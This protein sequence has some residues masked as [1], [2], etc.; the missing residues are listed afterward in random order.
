MP[1]ICLAYS[2]SCRGQKIQW[3]QRK[4]SLPFV[5]LLERYSDVNE[6]FFGAQQEFEFHFCSMSTLS[7]E[8]WLLQRQLGMEFPVKKATTIHT[9]RRLN[10]FLP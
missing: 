1:N 4:L 9:T 6:G 10:T 7:T 8:A 3:L 2:S 5:L